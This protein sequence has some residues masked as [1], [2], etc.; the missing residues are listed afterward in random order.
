MAHARTLLSLLPALLVLSFIGPTLTLLSRPAD[1]YVEG[2]ALVTFKESVSLGAAKQALHNHNLDFTKHFASISQHSGKHI[3]LIRSKN[4]STTQ[5][6]AELS[7]D[8]SVEVA[9]PNFVR[10]FFATVPNDTFF[11]QLWGLRNTGQSVNGSTGVSGSDIKF[12]QAWSLARPSTNQVVVAVIDSGVN[13]THPDLVANIW[14]NPGEISNN[15]VDDDGNGYVDDYHGYDFGD[16]D[17]DP[18]TT[19]VHGTHVAGTI[20]ATGNNLTGVIG[21]DFQAKIMALKIGQDS[22]PESF[23]DSAAIQAIDYCVLMKGRG[24]NIVAINASWGGGAFDSALRTAIQSA[25]NVGIIFCAAAGNNTANNDTTP[26][27]PG[28]YRLFNMIVVAATDM[29][30]ALGSFSDYGP[31]TVDLGAPG[32]NILSTAPTNGAPTIAIVQDGST[33][34]AASPFEFSTATTGLTEQIYD[35]GLGYPTNFLPLF[36]TTLLLFNGALCFLLKRS[37][38]QLWQALARLLSITTPTVIF[39]ELFSTPA[40][41]SRPSAYPRPM[42]WP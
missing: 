25:G 28:N 36:I 18:N 19:D 27:Y 38:T 29:N 9:E 2:E 17:S 3:G 30:D 11:P 22:N 5:L 12:V 15:G 24:V 14:T 20:A 32:V 42:A 8:P 7:H 33:V 10:R 4:H 31:N 37:P 23:N 6:I 41:G 35:C 26:N 34:Y 40:I 39:Q 16:G 1:E 21:V 13:Y